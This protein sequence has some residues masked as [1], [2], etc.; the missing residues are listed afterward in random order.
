MS[1]PAF[2]S[3]SYQQYKEDQKV[4]TTW[5]YQ[6]ARACGY[7]SSITKAQ[8]PASKAPKAA[9]EIITAPTQRLKGKARKLSKQSGGSGPVEAA[10]KPLKS[11]SHAMPISELT[12][13]VEAISKSNKALALPASVQ[14]VLQRAIA[15]RKRCAN[16]YASVGA[17][18]VANTGHRHVIEALQNALNSLTPQDSTAGASTHAE[19]AVTSDIKLRY[20]CRFFAFL[21]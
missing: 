13:S 19:A 6:T 1:L 4:F 2:L 12:D 14:A 16:W 10:A 7:K 20:V 11:V 9:A 15:A 3:S 8:Q 5:L 17:D 21:R 18:A